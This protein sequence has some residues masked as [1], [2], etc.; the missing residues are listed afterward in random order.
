MDD[1]KITI[2]MGTEEIQAMESFLLDHPELGSRSNFIRTTVREYINR[3]ADRTPADNNKSGIF[4]E[5]P[6]FEKNVMNEVMRMN[7]FVSEEEFIRNCVRDV[8][9]KEHADTLANMQA[10]ARDVSL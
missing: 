7:F 6:E 9:K 4:I 3:D 8:I 5:L 10:V 1:D 2:R